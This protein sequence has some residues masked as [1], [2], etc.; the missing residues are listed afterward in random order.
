[1]KPVATRSTFGS[2]YLHLAVIAAVIVVG[3]CGIAQFFIAPRL[4]RD[5]A[6][7][8]ES[9][10]RSH[11]SDIVLH[12][13][14]AVRDE[15]IK[16]GAISEDQ[17]FESFSYDEKDAVLPLLRNCAISTANICIGRSKSVFFD[18]NLDVVHPDSFRFAVVLSANLSRTP[19]FLFLWEGIV[20]VFTALAF[21][22]LQR[23]IAKKERYLL[24]R[25]GAAGTAFDRV[26]DLFNDSGSATDE[27]DTLSRSAEDLVR[28]LESYKERFER[29][30]R[31]EQLGL[32]V[33]QVS[34]DLKAPL[35]EAEN[36][37]ASLPSLL[38]SVPR[39][40]LQEAVDSL[41]AR[42]RTGKEVLNRTLRL[43]K[44]AVVARDVVSL[45]EVLSRTIERAKQ[46]PKLSALSF[47]VQSTSLLVVKGDKIRLETALLNLFEN[48]A[49]EKKDATVRLSLFTTDRGLGRIF[50]QDDG[51][52]IPDDLLDRI[53]EPLVTFKAE[54]TGLGLS[55]TKEILAQHGGT[56]RALPKAGGA[57]FEIELPVLGGQHA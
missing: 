43:T 4:V 6:L 48:T 57:C 41:I 47:S 55:S 7:A 39:E 12:K 2:I 36:F 54:G 15:L 27:F 30:T 16:A 49:D 33:G 25:L 17:Q 50:Y 9:V 34:H 29:K 10:I 52:G 32:T 11:E 46:S 3:F 22:M 5:R 37:L 51:R 26:R 24:A 42:I 35:N 23:S 56:I 31:L 38:D 18:S 14:R 13:T 20:A 28:A 45:D 8:V 21:L 40:Q 1:V 44:Q 19:P 53:F